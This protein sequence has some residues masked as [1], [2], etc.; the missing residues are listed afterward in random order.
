SESFP[1]L[2]IVVMIPFTY[3]IADGMAIGFILYPILKVAIG[4]W[5]EVTPTLYVIAGLFL[6]NFVF[7]VIG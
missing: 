6:M 2:F 7:H 5:K 3:S 1:A 4:K